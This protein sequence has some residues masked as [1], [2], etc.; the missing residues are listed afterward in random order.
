MKEMEQIEALLQKPYFV[1]DFLPEQVPQSFQG[2]FFEIEEYFLNSKELVN[3]AD[4]FTRIILKLL[5]YF[6]ADIFTDQWS[7]SRVKCSQLSTLVRDMV[8]SKNGYMNI[9]FAGIN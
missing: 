2:S 8:L 5:C 9:L 6:K 4:K 7:G 3:I 1:I